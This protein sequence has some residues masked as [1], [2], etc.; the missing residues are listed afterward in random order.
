ME[1]QGRLPSRA[2]LDVVLALCEECTISS[3]RS[4]LPREVFM[5][6]TKPEAFSSNALHPERGMPSKRCWFIPQS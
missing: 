4:P 5:V 1:R 6:G 2:L 3:C